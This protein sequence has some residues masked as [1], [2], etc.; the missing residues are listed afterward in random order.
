ME[1]SDIRERPKFS[2]AKR[3]Q[4]LG[5]GRPMMNWLTKFELNPISHLSAGT[6]K[7]L[8]RLQARKQINRRNSV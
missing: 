4:R 8:D 3:D 7:S 2:E 1:K 6:Q 5:Q